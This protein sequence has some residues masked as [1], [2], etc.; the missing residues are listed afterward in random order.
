MTLLLGGVGA[1]SLGA[2]LRGNPFQDSMEEVWLR[3]AEV[4]GG[5][6]EV[7]SRKTLEPRVLRIVVELDDVEAV[8]ALAV[9]VVGDGLAHTVV[10]A[11]YVLGAGPRFVA[12]RRPPGV[13]PQDGVPPSL[14]VD[15]PRA[16]AVFGP[17]ATSLCERLPGSST[18]TGRA[19]EIEIVWDGAESD[20]QV[21]GDMLRLVAT[22]ASFGSDHLRG[23]STLDD[24]TYEPRSEEGPRVRVRRGLALIYLLARAEADEPVYVARTEARAG[25]PEI[26]AH[27][28]ERGD[29]DPALPEGV[30]DPS[31][32]G[33]LLRLAPAQMRSDGAT[34]EVVWS[35]PP[36]L[37]QAK[38]AIRVLAEVGASSGSR[39]AFR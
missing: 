3:A 33:E 5:R 27:I 32:A 23:L 6:L 22:L 31:V 35:E 16:A 8:A 11:A 24:A 13:A 7:V 36:S 19:H 38:A 26:E 9:P 30:L 25:T 17:D 37:D 10:R 15:H 1:L 20:V 34:I 28:D 21:L 18:V 2:S 29:A 39:G 14:L 12:R 4:L